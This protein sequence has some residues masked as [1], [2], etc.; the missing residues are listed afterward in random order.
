MEFKNHDKLGVAGTQSSNIK[1]YDV[2]GKEAATLV[3]EYKELGR[4]K[5]E[6]TNVETR[7]ALSL[8]GH[9]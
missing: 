2:P 5:V 4:Y 1:V 7:H 3:D 6:F 8:P 9:H